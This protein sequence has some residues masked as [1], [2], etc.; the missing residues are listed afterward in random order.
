MTRRVL[1]IISGGIA[2]YKSL[3]LVRALRK[4][5]IAVRAVLTK[6][7]EQFVTPLSLGVL[8]ED[9][10]S[11]PYALGAYPDWRAATEVETTGDLNELARAY[12][13]VNCSMCHSPGGKGWSPIDLQFHT[14][15][16]RAG[17]PIIRQCSPIDII[18]G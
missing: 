15:L 12:L 5:G 3:E 10:P 6:S 11:A 1:L 18:F 8:T 9:L 7:A 16:A 14:P 13:D 4:R 2:A 17:L